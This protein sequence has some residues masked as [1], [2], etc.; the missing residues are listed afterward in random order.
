MS[1]LQSDAPPT[2]RQRTEEEPTRS[3]IWHADGSVVLQAEMTLFRVHWSVLSLHSSA[4]RELRDR[5]QPPDQYMIESCPVIELPDSSRDLRHLLNALY[6]PLLFSGGSL[7]FQFISGIV[8]L[9]RKY[10]FDKLLAAAVERLTYE[11]PTT[12]AANDAL[13]GPNASSYESCQIAPYPGIVFDTITL[14]RANNLHALLPCAYARAVLYAQELILDGIS[15]ENKVTITL[16]AMDQRVCIIGRKKMLEAQWQHPHPWDWLSSDAR[17]PGC[18]DGDACA[19]AKKM[20]LRGALESGTLVVLRRPHSI[21]VQFCSACHPEYLAEMALG[22][23]ELWDKLPTFFGLPPWD[24][25]K[26]DL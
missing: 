17:A 26:N 11:N 14:A 25:L 23:K 3:E 18:T 12:L 15:Y 21:Q 19:A 22:R 6:D 20:L 16:S 13:P 4:F 8:R 5:P 9:G 1:Q 2:K 7:P 24:E 10:G